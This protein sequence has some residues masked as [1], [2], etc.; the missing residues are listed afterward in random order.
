MLLLL[1]FDRVPHR[2]RHHSH[3]AG[4]GRRH[5]ADRLS[6]AADLEVADGHP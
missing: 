5:R 6:P 3:R 1:L 2:P 4:R